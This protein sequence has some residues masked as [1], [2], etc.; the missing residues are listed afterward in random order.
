MEHPI[1][2][3]ALAPPNHER[4]AHLQTETRKVV[5]EYESSRD[6]GKV[7]KRIIK[8]SK[9]VLLWFQA[10]EALPLPSLLE[11][12]P[13]YHALFNLT[14]QV[15]VRA[16][17]IENGMLGIVSR[18]IT[19]DVNALLVAAFSNAA[20]EESSKKI[21][22]EELD[23]IKSL[24]KCM[25][26]Q[27]PS[28]RAHAARGIFSITTVYDYKVRASEEPGLLPLLVNSLSSGN[29]FLCTN[30]AGALAN[31]AI[32][33]KNKQPIVEAGALPTLKLLANEHQ[34]ETVLHQVTRCMF[35]LCA[36]S[37][38]RPKMDDMVIC[39]TR[40]LNYIN[41]PD[42]LANTIGFLVNLTCVEFAVVEVKTFLLSILPIFQKSTDPTVDRQVVRMLVQ[43]C[44]KRK[45]KMSEFLK[46]IIVRKVKSSTDQIFVRDVTDLFAHDSYDDVEERVCLFKNDFDDVLFD[47]L[48]KF[49]ENEAIACNVLCT[50]ARLS[51]TKDD[52]EEMFKTYPERIKMICDACDPSHGVRMRTS[53]FAVLNRLSKTNCMKK[54]LQ[55]AGVLNL[56][57][58][59]FFD[60]RCGVDARYQA[61]K[62]ICGLSGN[63]SL[64]FVR[65]SVQFGT[66]VAG[67]AARLDTDFIKWI[68]D[69]NQDE[70][71]DLHMYQVNVMNETGMTIPFDF[72]LFEPLVFAR[73]PVLLSSLA[74]YR[75]TNFED[76]IDVS[77]LPL[78]SK[79]SWEAFVNI[80]HSRDF[81]ILDEGIIKGVI[82]LAKA[83]G[84]YDD[85]EHVKNVGIDA[86]LEWMNFK[87]SSSS[88]W[89]PAMDCML[90]R[91]HTEITLQVKP[92]SEKPLFTPVQ[93]S[94]FVKS[95]ID[96]WTVND[97]DAARSL[98]TSRPKRICRRSDSSSFHATVE[99]GILS[100]RSSYFAG[101]F[102]GSWSDCETNTFVFDCTVEVL[103]V[104]IRYLHYGY[105]EQLKV[106]LMGNPELTWGT[107]KIAHR[108]EILGLQHQCEFLLSNAVGGD[109]KLTTALMLNT[110][111]MHVPCLWSNIYTKYLNESQKYR[112]VL[113]AYPEIKEVFKNAGFEE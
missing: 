84:V 9:E 73:F 36:D 108:F 18:W 112:N 57:T 99:R 77:D 26:A 85:V 12:M 16:S 96:Q 106:E 34:N 72:G 48:I 103:V 67:E 63:G 101:L 107:L 14:T 91:Q 86:S 5:G 19:K 54:T 64:S 1:A 24:T 45:N 62:I 71:T 7:A 95:M 104:I 55:M 97:D 3:E 6:F 13:Y 87:K 79:S 8:L 37:T 50:V 44:I 35:S 2:H 89:I 83:L 113:C 47:V 25:T 56:A 20:F 46:Q 93:T 94:T 17:L 28:I 74:K 75:Q 69:M 68:T 32:H 51:S 31:I 41:N 78:V 33:P 65:D 10:G 11:R 15:C 58:F 90:H 60:E 98:I 49:K 22:V 53:A 82:S 42:I 100:A 109:A 61:G 43:F 29:D 4:G 105:D 38:N 21:I 81:K 92:Q 111:F 70:R 76:L 27:N 110:Q 102:R 59:A 30:A 39:V 80:L 23:G 88:T 40:L 52:V 66:S